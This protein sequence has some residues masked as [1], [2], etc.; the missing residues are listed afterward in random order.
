MLFFKTIR[1]KLTLWYS[2]LLLTTLVAFGII[3]YEYTERQLSV[4]LDKLLR[5]EVA[6]FKNRYD[7]RLRSQPSVIRKQ[8]FMQVQP[9]GGVTES[10]DSLSSIPGEVYRHFVLNPN[11][12]YIEVSSNTT[13][14][15][16]FQSHLIDTSIVIDKYPRDTVGLQTIHNGSGVKLRVASLE[17]DDIQVIVAYPLGQPGE[18]LDILFRVFVLLIPIAFAV[19]LG[20][21][22]ILAYISLRSVDEVTIT[23]REISA[24][25]LDKQI[26]H[27]GVNDEIG[28][29]V[30]TLNEMLARLRQ[31]FNEIKQF[32]SDASHE[33]RTPLTIMRGEVELALRSPKAP[34]EYRRVLV[35]NLEEI[36]RLASIIDS[37]LEF[38][39]TEPGAKEVAMERVNFTSILTELYEDSKMIAEKKKIQ[40]RLERNDA[41]C[42]LADAIRIRQLFLNL[43]DNAIKYTPECGHVSLSSELEGGFVKVKVSDDGIGIA[44]DDQQKIFHRFYRVDKGRS[45]DMGGTGL[46]LSIAQSI[47]S[48]HR[49]HIAVESV[50]GKGTTFTVLLPVAQ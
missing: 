31:S 14:A 45:R 37:L 25:N 16:L 1:F 50:L 20:G 34:E 33:L 18:V 44:E 4:N 40:V 26:P 36:L 41:A 10:S 12:T 11:K 23:A 43:I 48:S 24:H 49:G 35:S 39:K 7:L 15:I 29:L 46:G 22:W 19:S 8:P 32:S 6:W 9:E 27:R 28:R 5:Y 47:T 3:A 13:G 21:G 2:F 42:I 38:T 30:L 17:T